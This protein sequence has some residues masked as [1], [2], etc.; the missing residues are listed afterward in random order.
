MFSLALYFELG[1]LSVIAAEGA[2][3]SIKFNH[4]KIRRWSRRYRSNGDGGR[5][6]ERSIAHTFL[7]TSPTESVTAEDEVT[8]LDYTHL[9]RKS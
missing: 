1:N 7:L 9:E 4:L 6:I 3:I 8:K 5:S 2:P